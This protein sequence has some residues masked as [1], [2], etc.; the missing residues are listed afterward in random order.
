MLDQFI[1]FKNEQTILKNWIRGNVTSPDALD[2]FVYE[3]YE[4]PFESCIEETIQPIIHAAT[5][6]IIYIERNIDNGVFD[7][8]FLNH[9]GDNWHI[10][11][12]RNV[13]PRDPKPGISTISSH[14]SGEIIHAFKLLENITVDL[15]DYRVLGATSSYLAIYRNNEMKRIAV[16]NP[17]FAG[18]QQ[19]SGDQK[20]LLKIERILEKYT[21]ENSQ[22]MFK[23]TP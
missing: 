10:I 14:D 3:D 18:L 17:N 9:S 20:I 13:Y 16:Y 2:P 23:A 19:F 11:S 15:D 12:W 1:S 21:R 5:F 4:S 7:I 8:F 6:Y 22:T